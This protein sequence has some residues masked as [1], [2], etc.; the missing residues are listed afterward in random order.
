MRVKVGAAIIN[1]YHSFDRYKYPSN[2]SVSKKIQRISDLRFIHCH[3]AMIGKGYETNNYQ[4][5]FDPNINHKLDASKD[6][7]IYYP[8]SNLDIIDDTNGIQ[9]KDMKGV[10]HFL[11]LP[12]RTSI[13][14]VLKVKQWKLY[15]FFFEKQTSNE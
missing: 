15:S 9:C 10:L 7:K 6:N 2:K 8:V 3:D 11:L 5:C 4:I 14:T 1:N 12:R 13:M